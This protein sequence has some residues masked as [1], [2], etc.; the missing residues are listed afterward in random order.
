MN[1]ILVNLMLQTFN[2]ID[3]DECIISGQ[4][5]DP[6]TNVCRSHRCPTSSKFQILSQIIN[7][8]IACLGTKLKVHE[9]ELVAS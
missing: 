4:R 7:I 2:S 1:D 5:F 3:D 8:I 9:S 6:V